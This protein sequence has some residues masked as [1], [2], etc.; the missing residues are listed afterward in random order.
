MGRG[1]GWGRGGQR[2]N[3]V[4]WIDGREQVDGSGEK[5]RV[6]AATIFWQFESERS[7]ANVA[8]GWVA[9]GASAS[10]LDT[11]GVAVAHRRDPA[12]RLR[13]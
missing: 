2:G 6:A 1:R 4:E 11:I 8:P 12:W 3:A 10:G 9:V 5:G 13:T 7:N